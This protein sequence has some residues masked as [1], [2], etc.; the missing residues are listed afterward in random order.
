MALV[1]TDTGMSKAVNAD[2]Q[3]IS[4]KITHV[5]VG[6]NGYEP[7]SSQTELENE[8]EVVEIQGGETIS[9]TQVQLTALFD[10]E[11]EIQGR[12]VGFYL[13]DGTLFAVE[14]DPVNVIMYKSGSVGSS[15]L[16]I[17]DIVLDSVPPSSVTVNA[18]SFTLPN[19]DNQ[20]NA[21]VDGRFD[22]WYEGTTQTTSGYGSDTMW[23]N[24]NI[25]STKVHT[26]EDLQPDDLPALENPT[27][28]YFSRTVVTSVA[29]DG[30]KVD[31]SQ[32]I[33]NVR[34][35]AGQ[36]NIYE[37]YA[38]ADSEKEIAVSFT[39]NF[40]IGGSAEVNGISAQKLTLS[41]SWKRYKVIIDMPSITGKTIGD[42]SYIEPKFF[43][44]AGVDFD[45]ESAE[46]GQQSGTF[47]VA[48]V[49][50]H[51]GIK[52]RGFPEEISSQSLLRVNTEGSFWQGTVCG[53]NDNYNNFY[54][55]AYM[56]SGANRVNLY[57]G[58]RV[59]NFSNKVVPVVTMVVEPVCNNATFKDALATYQ[60]VSV[61]LLGPAVEGSYIVT[62][63]VTRVDGR[64]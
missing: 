3:G 13:E 38:R 1:I 12:E 22:F 21:V 44:D 15:A 11:D 31:K 41:D 59:L 40:G 25:G 48:C 46:L 50:L 5:G 37:F 33:D 27:A 9:P 24:T 35:F 18:S 45:I 39:Q 32:R 64:I 17:F 8:I 56:Y 23:R 58:S 43:F 54:Y 36:K 51:K 19:V 26:R 52:S 4:L 60:N 49:D 16:E 53:G 2:M 47:D 14:S 61:R 29:G 10:G 62:G 7:D 55:G 20:S 63:D 30:N 6:L 57:G 42:G 28:R 34:R